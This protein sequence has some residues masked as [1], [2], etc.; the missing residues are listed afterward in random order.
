M[1]GLFKKRPRCLICN[2]KVDEKTGSVVKYRY[3]EAGEPRL[4]EAHL[5]RKCTKKMEK[6]HID[7]SGYDGE[8][9]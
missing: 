9:L 5:C 3:E 1:I 6:T 8:P 4:G 7:E 2:R